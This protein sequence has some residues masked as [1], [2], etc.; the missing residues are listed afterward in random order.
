MNELQLVSQLGQLKLIG[1]QQA[2][3]EQFESPKYA[4]LS[5]EERLSLVLDR[6]ILH[7]DNKRLDN[8]LRQAKLRHPSA[9]IEEVRYDQSRG[10]QKSTVLQIAKCSFIDHHH[11]L[12]ITGATGCGKTYLACAI[13][14]QACRLGKRVRY[15]HLPKWFEAMAISHVDGS[16]T[17]HIGLLQKIDLL[18]LDDFGLTSL[19]SQQR[20]DLFTLIEDRYQLQSTIITS[21]FPVSKWHSTLN[22]PTLADAIMDRILENS[23]RI[24]LKGASMRKSNL[25]NNLALA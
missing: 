1:A 12:L 7:R 6:Q 22:E 13:A 11:N 8:L 2:L 18:I 21:Q 23:H 3:R 25:D 15:L 5:F 4:S 20:H 10:I 14:H 17:R 19:K 16:F 9:A 24:E